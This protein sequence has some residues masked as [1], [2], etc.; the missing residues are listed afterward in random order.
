M[1]NVSNSIKNKGYRKPQGQPRMDN[2]KTLETQDTR[3]R[4]TKHNT[5]EQQ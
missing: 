4:Q 5:D 3:R 1:Y 2:S